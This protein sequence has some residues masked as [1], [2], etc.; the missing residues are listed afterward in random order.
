[1]IATHNAIFIFAQY[2]SSIPHELED[3][4]RIN[5]AYP[6]LVIRYMFRQRMSS[7]LFDPGQCVKCCS[8]V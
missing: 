8:A 1:L 3:A 5:G 6:L 2:R 7:G 4:V